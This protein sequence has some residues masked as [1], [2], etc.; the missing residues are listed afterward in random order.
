M[1]YLRTESKTKHLMIKE[2]YIN[3]G[4]LVIY[5]AHKF[6][7]LCNKFVL[8]SLEFRLSINLGKHR[9]DVNEMQ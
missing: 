8:A 1:I 3:S 2:L 5:S 4:R 7:T 6:Q 9:E